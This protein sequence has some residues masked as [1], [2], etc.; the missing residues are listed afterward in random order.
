MCKRVGD[1]EHGGGQFIYEVL[2]GNPIQDVKRMIYF[3]ADLHFGHANIIRFCNRPFQSAQEM[4]ETLIA[5]WNA[6]VK[7]NDDVYILGDLFY[8]NVTPAEDTLKRLK[9]RKHLIL[10]N[11]DK[12]LTATVDFTR[13]FAEVTNLLTYKRD[14]VKYTL[15]HYPMLSWDGRGHGGYMI[16]GHNHNNPLCYNDP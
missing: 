3:T 16:H 6:V 8:R 7:G 11:H 10:G 1:V 13:Y 15:C 9:G 2:I 14:G 12:R 4:D 5:N